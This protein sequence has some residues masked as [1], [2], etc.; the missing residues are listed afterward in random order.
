VVVDF[1][2]GFKLPKS[3]ISILILSNRFLR[4]KIRYLIIFLVR[5]ALAGA[6]SCM[7]SAFFGEKD[8]LESY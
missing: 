6:F 7:K 4:L 2:I 3:L 1:L 5:I 8:I